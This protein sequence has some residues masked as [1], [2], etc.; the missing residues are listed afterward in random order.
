MYVF[1]GFWYAFGIVG[2]FVGIIQYKEWKAPKQPKH[3]EVN[4][5]DCIVWYHEDGS[6]STG[7]SWGHEVAICPK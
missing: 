3:I 5:Q 2:I 4:G 1:I 7:A 6:T